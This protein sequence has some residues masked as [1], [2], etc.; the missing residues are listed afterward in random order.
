MSY[1]DCGLGESDRAGSIG[2]A[3]AYVDPFH[4]AAGI[5][6]ISDR[7]RNGAGPVALVFG[8]NGADQLGLGIG[9]KPNRIGSERNVRTILLAIARDPIEQLA[10]FCRGLDAYAGEFE[11]YP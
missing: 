2:G 7:R 5:D 4:S 10:P 9:E 3:G 8:A 1:R 6:N 11:L